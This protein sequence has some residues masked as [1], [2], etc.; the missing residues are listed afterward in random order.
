MDAW[1][2]FTSSRSCELALHYEGM[3]AA[4]RIPLERLE[5]RAKTSAIELSKLVVKASEQFSRDRQGKQNTANDA[6][7][8]QILKGS[9]KE[10][11]YSW[12][13]AEECPLPVRQETIFHMDEVA[14]MSDSVSVR[15]R[16]GFVQR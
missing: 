14:Y 3:N 8:P 7:A 6:D 2:R 11:R 15:Q 16:R 9:L 1:E 4:I 10:T 13:G 5:D 12:P